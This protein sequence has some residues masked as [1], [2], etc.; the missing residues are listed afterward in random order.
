MRHYRLRSVAGFFVAASLAGCATSNYH[1]PEG[2]GHT[3]IITEQEIAKSSCTNVWD[4]LRKRARMYNYAEDRY[5]RPRFITTKRGVSTIALV[6][7]DSPMVVIDGARLVDVAAL[8]DMPT[9]SVQSIELQSGITGT[10]SQG[11]NAVAGVIYIHTKEAS[12]S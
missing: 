1:V 8:R 6:G 2:A 10:S 7:S 3:D 5:G 4:L 11:T 12:S 9:D